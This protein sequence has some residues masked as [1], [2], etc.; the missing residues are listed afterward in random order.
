MGSSSAEDFKAM[1]S[2]D[3]SP[4]LKYE[5]RKN[6][7]A[8]LKLISGFVEHLVAKLK[9]VEFEFKKKR[10]SSLRTKFLRSLWTS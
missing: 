2:D 4:P 10:M 1:D 3:N 6:T 7:E 9:N 5:T 8:N